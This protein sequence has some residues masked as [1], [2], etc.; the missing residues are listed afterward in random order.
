M[1]LRGYYIFHATIDSDEPQH[2]HV[3]WAW[4][5]GL[6]QYRDVF[7]NHTPLFHLLTA[8]IL[9]ALGEQAGIIPW[10]RLAMV[11]FF[12][13]CLWCVYR[14]GRRLFSE[15]V[16]GWAM[17]V[18]GFLPRFFI[19]AGQY[20]SDDLWVALW[21]ATLVV[22]VERR[23]SV[24]RLFFAGFLIGCMLTTSLKTSILLI[25]LAV[26]SAGVWFA[27]LRAKS[28]ARSGRMA[29]KHI[30]GLL[31]GA[32]IAPLLLLA[33]YYKQHALPA[34]IQETV[35]HNYVPRLGQWKNWR[36]AWFFPVE[37]VALLSI[38][39]PLWRSSPL[40]ELRQRRV[41]VFLSGGLYLALLVSFWPLL[42]P[43]SFLPFYPIAA[44]FLTAFILAAY[45]RFL[46]VKRVILSALVAIEVATIIAT[47]PP[48]RQ[49][50]IAEKML[51]ADVLRLTG[52]DDYVM[53]GKGETIFR[54]RAFFPIFEHITRNRLALGLTPDSM[55]ADLVATRTCVAT[56]FHPFTKQ[57]TSF[58]DKNYLPVGP[59]SVVG[60]ILSATSGA[61][62]IK[63]QIVIPASYA[64]ISKS[65]PATGMLDGKPYSGAIFLEA[66]PH[67]FQGQF[68]EGRLAVVWARALE[69]GFSPFVAKPWSVP[70]VY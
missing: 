60:Q 30:A 22:L 17:I 34:L 10:M 18:A 25:A 4:T 69:L 32:L 43:E 3:T 31:A 59:L 1:L 45:P 68:S 14:L 58:I 15:E 38:S 46:G 5:K 51:L 48:R 55:P 16:G 61:K 35:F 7:D 20:R 21:L 9:S 47:N 57:D 52:P 6:L 36:M 67:Q 33:Y 70:V 66:G 24:W 37:V 41:L 62:A 63:F 49:G 29:W 2:L 65:G 40:L 11:P 53:D 44:L 27:S 12:L 42:A 50:T 13:F 28:C 64:I 23:L 56:T 39:L 19:I 8:P 26:A 54:R